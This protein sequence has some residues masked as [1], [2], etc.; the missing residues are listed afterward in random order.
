MARRY[1][2]F[3]EGRG[4]AHRGTFVIDTSGVIRWSVVN[5]IPDARDVSQYRKV[6]DG[7]VAA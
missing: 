2:V 3:D 5:A 4:Y 6:L 1:G 7:L